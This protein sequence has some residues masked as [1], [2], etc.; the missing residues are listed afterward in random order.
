MKTIVF[1]LYSL[2]RVNNSDHTAT[3]KRRPNKIINEPEYENIERTIM[4]EIV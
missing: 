3:C 2:L 1:T 4:R